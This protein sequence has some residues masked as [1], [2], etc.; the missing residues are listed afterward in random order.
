MCMI[1]ERFLDTSWSYFIPRLVLEFALSER[2]STSEENFPSYKL[3]ICDR[4]YW[5]NGE[6][7]NVA[8]WMISRS[9]EAWIKSVHTHVKI[10]SPC[11]SLGDTNKFNLKHSAYDSMEWGKHLVNL[12]FPTTNK[13][14]SF[15]ELLVC[16]AI[17]CLCSLH[18]WSLGWQGHYV[19][20][21]FQQDQFQCCYWPR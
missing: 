11:I 10:K 18:K 8:P 13:S 3:C 16:S 14:A 6:E 20:V 2:W 12:K 17:C 1:F 5:C 4:L 21:F 19:A 9:T 7:R 15:F